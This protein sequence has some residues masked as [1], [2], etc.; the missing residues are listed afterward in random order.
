VIYGKP[1][2]EFTGV[3]LRDF[4]IEM[5]LHSTLRSEPLSFYGTLLKM[6]ESGKPYTVFIDYKNEGKYTVRNVEGEEKIWHGGR[7]AVM[8]ITLTLREYVE[9]L[10]TEAERK[11]REDELKREDTGKGG[12]DKLAGNGEITPATLSPLIDP[13]TRMVTMG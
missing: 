5:T 2:T 13:V 12:P 4:T 3:D 10:P 9:S 6:A 8:D 7:P 1:L 11:L